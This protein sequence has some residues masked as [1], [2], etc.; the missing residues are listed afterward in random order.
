[1]TVLTNRLATQRGT[2]LIK[3]GRQLT[4]YEIG[5]YGKSATLRYVAGSNEPIYPVGYVQHKNPIAKKRTVNPYSVNGRKGIHEN[6]RINT[7]LMKLMLKQPLNGRTAEYA[8]NRI[9]LFSAQWGKCAIT[10]K[11]FTSLE[12]IHCHHITP[13]SKG[14]SDKYQNLVLVL[15]PVHKLIHATDSE[16]IS[17]YLRILALDDKQLSKVNNYRVKAGNFKI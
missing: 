12:S 2:R 16:T 13:K 4:Q 7:Y 9:S 17:Y 8:D 15:L 6:L 14:G 10:G 1:M 5:R 3:T 11:E